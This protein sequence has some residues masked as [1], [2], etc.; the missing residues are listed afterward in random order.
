MSSLQGIVHS[1]LRSSLEQGC[2]AGGPWTAS[3]L[4]TARTASAAV[5]AVVSGTGH[6]CSRGPSELAAPVAGGGKGFMLLV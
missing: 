2:L 6:H 4:F 1:C 3:I 5:P